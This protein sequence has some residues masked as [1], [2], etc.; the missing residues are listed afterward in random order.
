MNIIESSDQ[1]ANLREDLS[2]YFRARSLVPIFGAGF[3]VG[4]VSKNGIVPDTRKM[5]DFM[6]SE[7]RK[8]SNVPKEE[9]LDDYS[10]RELCALFEDDE[11]VNNSVRTKYYADNFSEVCFNDLRKSVLDIDWDY[12]YT[13]NVD[14]GIERCGRFS[15]PVVANNIINEEVYKNYKCVIK[16]HGDI[17]DIVTNKERKSKIFTTDEY[18][19]SVKTN[20]SL[21]DKLENDYRFRNVLFFGC[22]LEEELD[23]Q[24]FDI[25]TSEVDN[26]GSRRILFTNKLP[27]FKEKNVL[28]GQYKI[29]DVV[30]IPD[31]D[32]WYSLLIDAWEDAQKVK[33][34]FLSAFSDLPKRKLNLKDKNDSY[35]YFGQ[36]LFS[37]KTKEIVYPYYFIHRKAADSYVAEIEQSKVLLIQGRSVSGRSYLL[38]DIYN[39]FANK[40]VFFFPTTIRINDDSVNSLI[41]K[42]SVIVLFDVNVL[43]RVQL[44]KI[45][46][47]AAKIHTNDS[48]FVIMLSYNDSDS[49]GIIKYK[50]KRNEF[51][52]KDIVVA[53]LHYKFGKSEVLEL[54]PKLTALDIPV[55]TENDTIFGNVLIAESK[56]LKKGKYSLQRLRINSVNDIVLYI[57]LAVNGKIY[58]SE[59]VK[60]D[61]MHEIVNAMAR[62]PQF[63]EEIKTD[64]LEKDAADP[65]NK[66][67][68]LNAELW[69]R[70]QLS[71]YASSQK[72]Y[73]LISNAYYNIVSCIIQT[74][75]D[76]KRIRE[77]YRKYIYFDS[78]N[79]I[80]IRKNKNNLPLIITIY[81]MLNSRLSQDYNFVHQFAKGYLNL[82]ASQIDES[83][84]YDNFKNAYKKIIVAESLISDAIE[85]DKISGRASCGGYHKVD[86]LSHVYFTKALVLS[87]LCLVEHLSILENTEKAIS[88]IEDAMS[89]F[90]NFES[91]LNYGDN[92]LIMKFLQ[93]SID[94]PYIMNSYGN[95][96]TE[97]LT[98]VAGR[99]LKY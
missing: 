46:L 41:N 33:P 56:S 72:N 89:D 91:S 2:S 61:I 48:S 3:S 69:L 39:S 17:K 68:V 43:T 32:G 55:F 71:D 95:K 82:A 30:V 65:S 77:K 76:E 52:S 6:I 99:G 81:D 66:K 28:K 63:I 18:Q 36:S 75:G 49:M 11:Y 64:L 45:L 87:G 86:A 79:N 29:T 54:N 73:V 14:D 26:R 31:Y 37:Q 34:D 96:L 5:M 57:V 93:A 47:N 97:L 19:R 85:K 94:T 22:S 42:Q 15:Q 70:N 62:F 8:S 98:K 83:T 21:L 25:S 80:F 53:N 90:D 44:E 67:F 9:K 92:S 12:V 59:I 74:G 58:T 13:F 51:S 23:L 10:F 1:L 4:S 60:F 35:F 27:S 7:L 24:T 20:K 38:A 84:R 50:L 16:L 40:V 78:I 88:A